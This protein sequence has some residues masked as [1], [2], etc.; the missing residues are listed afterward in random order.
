LVAYDLGDHVVERVILDLHEYWDG[1]HAILDDT[2]YRRPRGI[3][4]L[5]GHLYD[6]RGHLIQEFENEYDHR[7][8]YLT[9]WT[10]HDEGAVT[11]G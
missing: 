2:E 9:G 4:R 5:R 7:G 6:S 11:R 8:E 1:S 3:R 10:R